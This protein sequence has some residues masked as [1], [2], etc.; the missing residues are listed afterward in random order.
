MAIFS[1]SGLFG[2]LLLLAAL[3]PSGAGATALAELVSPSSARTIPEGESA[4]GSVDARLSRLSAALRERV[5]EQAGLDTGAA[6]PDGRLA[7]VF[8][9]GGGRG[10]GWGNG[11]FRNGGF[12]NGGFRNGG[13]GNGGF[14]NGGFLNGGGF[15]N[16][17]FRN[18]W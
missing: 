7:F 14:R 2:F 8:A 16:G 12:G 4:P 15:R 3:A 1:R 9:N 10:I 17:G 5:G 13:W 6:G 18:Y 11:G